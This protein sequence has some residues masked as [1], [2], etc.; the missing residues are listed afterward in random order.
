MA[1]EH[2]DFLFPDA[3]FFIELVFFVVLVVGAVW[4]LVRTVRKRS[5]AD[6]L[7]KLSQLRDTGVLT[8]GEF[9]QRKA[10]LLG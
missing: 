8:N 4:L 10:R 9:E 5:V 1:P 2:S 6:E 7:A 3:T